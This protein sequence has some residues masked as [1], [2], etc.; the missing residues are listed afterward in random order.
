MC[1]FSFFYSGLHFDA[2]VVHRQQGET[3]QAQ[4]ENVAKT[5]CILE[6]ESERRSEEKCETERKQKK[7]LSYVRSGRKA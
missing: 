4:G 2:A 1:E 5:N 6:T 7:D 3:S